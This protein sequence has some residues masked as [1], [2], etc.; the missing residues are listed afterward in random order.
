MEGNSY[1]SVSKQLHF[2]MKKDMC[3][4]KQIQEIMKESEVSNNN[5]AHTY[6]QAYM[7]VMFNQM[8]SKKEIKFL[9]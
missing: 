9:G 4:K 1:K 6:M 3:M 2:F 5:N 7:N 8:Q